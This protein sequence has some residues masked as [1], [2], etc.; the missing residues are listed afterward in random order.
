LPTTF[1][2]LEGYNGWGHRTEEGQATTPTNRSPYICSGTTHY[3]QGKYRA[4]GIFDPSL[5]SDKVGCMAKLFGLVSKGLVSKGL[6]NLDSSILQPDNND[7]MKVGP[8][9]DSIAYPAEGVIPSL[10]GE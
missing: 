8:S 4:D 2:F 1:W 7:P 9:G 10:L 6:V 5:V 3:E